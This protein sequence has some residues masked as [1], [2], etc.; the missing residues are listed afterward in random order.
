MKSNTKNIVGALV[1]VLILFSTSCTKDFDK[2]N[3]DETLV[4]ED[5]VKPSMMFTSVLKNSVFSSYNT[6]IIA[7]YSGYYSNGAS[8]VIFKNANWSDPFNEFYRSYIINISEVIRLTANDPK[9]VNEHAMARVWKAWLFSQLTDLYGDVPYFESSKKVE[10]VVSQPKYDTQ[11]DIYTDLRKELKEAATQLNADATLASFGSADILMNGDVDKW[12]RFANS[13]RLRLAMRVR[14]ADDALAKQHIL[15]VVGA[16]LIDANSYN[17]YLT[18]IDGSNP[19]NRNPLWMD[20]INPYPQFASFTVSD[21]LKK[22]N[23]PRLPIF[24]VPAIDGVSGYNGRP[25]AMG[26]S[27][28]STIPG[29]GIY[30]ESTTAAQQQYFR[31]AVYPIIVMNAAEVYLLR[32][33]A[34][35]AGISTENAQLMYT[36]GI[37][38]SLTQFSVAPAAMSAYL[39]SSTA[40]LSGTVEEK[41]EQIIVQKFLGMYFQ[42]NEGYAEF[43]RTGY[44]R[45]WTGS[46]KGSTNSEIPRRLTYPLDEYAKNEANVKEATGR[47]ANGDTYMSRMWWD[48]KAGLPFHH[49]N[50]GIFPPE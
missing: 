20:P 32:A 44:P 6:S 42:I 45:I 11:K 22:L 7:E 25:I 46:D 47:L 36:N 23:D 13:L 27:D 8:G 18:T 26:A 3:T 35:L 38:Q 15:D 37:S 31:N 29:K 30:S 17:V 50:Q 10:E 40:T 33:E 49:A 41:L 2:I 24:L 12:K 14:Y 39:A 9:L 19:Q 1:A 21:N 34:A 48:A 5:I 43:R 4:T 28:V 16:P